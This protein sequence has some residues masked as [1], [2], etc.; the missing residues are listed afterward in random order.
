MLRTRETKAIR[1]LIY[2]YYC[3]LPVAVGG[4]SNM[5]DIKKNMVNSNGGLVNYLDN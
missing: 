2:K 1:N 3:K 4:N 5:M